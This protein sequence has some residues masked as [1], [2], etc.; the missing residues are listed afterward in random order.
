MVWRVR[1]IV[2]STITLLF[3]AYGMRFALR[4]D[5]KDFPK[6]LDDDFLA[7]Q[8]RRLRQLA[9]RM[10]QAG[11]YMTENSD[12]IRRGRDTAD[13]S[14]SPLEEVRDFRLYE[15]PEPA[16]PSESHPRA[17]RAARGAESIANHRRRR[18]RRGRR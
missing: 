11:K 8:V 4:M 3:G 9:E 14:I 5:M 18:P 15:A 13:V 1:A 10:S 2:L 7:I 6:H 16:H 17:A 12:A